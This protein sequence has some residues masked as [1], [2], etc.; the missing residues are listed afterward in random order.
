LREALRQLEAEGLLHLEP[1]KGPVVPS[2]SGPE[3]EAVYAVRRELEGYACAE[4]ARLAT[5]DDIAALRRSLDTMRRA[6]AARDFK[7][8]QHAK[9]AFY[10]RLYAAT[11]NA[12]LKRILQQLRARVTLIRGLDV[13]RS[14]RVRESIDGAKSI[15]DAL[16]RRDPAA[17]RRAAEQHISKAAPLALGAMQPA[18]AGSSR[19]SRA[20]R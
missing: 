20:A 3:A 12:E 4:V 5:A 13:N 7:A 16:A 18:A 6:V 19:T 9:T 8:L 10:D 14:E 2:L 17:A 15:L 11:G 1:N